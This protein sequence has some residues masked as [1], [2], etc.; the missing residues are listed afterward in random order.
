MGAEAVTALA[1]AITTSGSYTFQPLFSENGSS[2]GQ[3]LAV[4]VLFV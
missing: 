4:T 2:Q 3:N 1:G